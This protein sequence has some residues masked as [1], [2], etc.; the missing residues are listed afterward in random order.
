[1][2]AVPYEGLDEI[3]GGL[4]EP[5]GDRI[6]VSA[7]VPMRFVPGA[8]AVTVDVAEGSACE[9]IAATLPAARVVGA[10]QT[11]SYVTLRDADR[12]VDSDIVLTGDDAGA[13]AAV[14]QLLGA[15][16]GA[17]VVDGGGL[18]NS[19]LVEQL[20]VLLVSINARYRRHTGVRITDL[21]DDL[22]ATWTPGP[23]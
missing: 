21:P 16:A 22:V 18:R 15:L 1:M 6:V 11:L 4:V 19:R 20:T 14:A 9:R 12:P 23:G 13:K 3:V 8:G 2:I 7:V 5:I 17:R 10:L